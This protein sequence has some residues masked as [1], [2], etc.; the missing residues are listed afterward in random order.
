MITGTQTHALKSSP[1]RI[2]SYESA[3]SMIEQNLSACPN[4]KSTTRVVI[5]KQDV[6]LAHRIML[7]CQSCESKVLKYKRKI[8]YLETKVATLK[9]N[10]KQYRT[11]YQALR[12]AQR[13]YQQLME[14]LDLGNKKKTSQKETMST[15]LDH[16]INV[17]AVLSSYYIGTG[18]ADIGNVAAFLGMPGA[19]SFSRNYYDSSEHV[20]D[21]IISHCQKII[22]KSMDREVQKTICEVLLKCGKYTKNEI[23]S[24]TAAFM[25][26][27]KKLPEEIERVGIGASYDI[28]WQGRGTGKVFDSLSGHGYLIGCRTGDVISMGIRPKSC[29]NVSLRRRMV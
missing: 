11:A 25:R 29:K 2:V 13:R 22:C 21:L 19:H 1:N 10:R 14:R 3:K 7:R 6:S 17:R 15:F 12:F 18:P 26:G 9:S 16:D 4:C 8:I 23:Q 24:H 20:N 28:G 27:D 5:T